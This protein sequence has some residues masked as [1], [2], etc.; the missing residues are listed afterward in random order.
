[1]PLTKAGK[2]LSQGS[3][4]CLSGQQVGAN[5]ESKLEA[6]EPQVGLR[7]LCSIVS[8]KFYPHQTPSRFKV[9]AKGH[10]ISY[11][12]SKRADSQGSRFKQAVSLKGERDRSGAGAARSGSSESQRL[13]R[14]PTSCCDNAGV[15]G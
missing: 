13:Q 14:H 3:S 9:H 5:F 4:R 2:C 6:A 10:H 1:M 8:W 11:N 15:R 7:R 12:T